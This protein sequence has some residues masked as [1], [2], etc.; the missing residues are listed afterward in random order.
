MRPVATKAL[1]AELNCSI[2]QQTVTCTS[3][4]QLA[5][6]ESLIVR[7]TVQMEEPLEATLLNTLSVQGGETGSPEPLHKL[8]KLR[9]SEDEQTPFGVETYELTPEGEPQRA[10]EGFSFDTQAGSHPFQLTTTLD[11]DQA[12][13][14][15]TDQGLFPSA[16]ALPRDLHF[17]LPP[18][19]VGD[20]S[21]VP[22]CT[23]TQ[24]SA[25]LPGSINLCPADTA[26][27]VAYVAIYLE[28]VD[29]YLPLVIPVFNLVPG[30]GEPARFGLEAE[31]VPVVL[32]TRLPV[33][34]EYPVEVSTINTTEVA[35]LLS[36]QV[37]IW[38]VP[39]DSRHDSARGWEC[40]ENGYHEYS[41]EPA[42]PCVHEQQTAPT[43]FLT[44]PTSCGQA[45]S[46]TVTGDSW[47]TGEPGNEGSHLA[48]E[49][50]TFT[51]PS[52]LTGCPL[53]PFEPGLSVQPETQAASS[54]TGLDVDLSV[55]QAATESGAAPVAEADV[56]TTTV[57]LPEGLELN[58]SAANGLEDCSALQFGFEGSP[59]SEQTRNLAFSEGSPDCPDASKVGTVAITTPLLP[60]ETVTGAVYLSAQHTSPFQAP[61][62][63][64]LLAEDKAK[65]VRVKL[66]GTVTPLPCGPAVLDL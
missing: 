19:L 24:F 35:Q 6:Y 52:G 23:D 2:S 11:L 8:L 43:A 57:T 63:L 7:I 3:S 20:P 15:H 60:G 50:S 41:L 38:G 4:R 37:T 36:A 40:L 30:P 17:K 47:P 53:L 25:V 39:G 10:G 13:A 22:A 26:I 45:P 1:S 28:N 54:P 14:N 32:D 59:E 44:L 18:G 33:G 46:S 65:G 66:A 48:T 42:P 5:P 64:Y 31:E 51:F 62:A 55:P 58:P 56:H 29:A 16:P 61:L 49:N 27:G 34:G 12:L 21:A 9:S